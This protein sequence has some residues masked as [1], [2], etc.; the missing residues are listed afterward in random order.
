MAIKFLLLDKE[1]KFYSVFGD[2]LDITGHKL[3]VAFDEAKAVELLNVLSPDF[4]ILNFKDI[5]FFWDITKK[6]KFLLPIFLVEDYEQVEAIKQLG[7]S[8]FNI[9]MLPFNPLEFLNKTAKFLRLSKSIKDT[10]PTN[11]GITNIILSL[12]SKQAY[13]SLLL[14]KENRVCEVFLKDGFVKGLSCT[15]A[16]FMEIIKMEDVSVSLFPYGSEANLNTYFKSNEEFFS[17]FTLPS[18]EEVQEVAQEVRLKIEGPGIFSISDGLFLLSFI[19]KN[20]L[21]QKNVYLRIYERDGLRIPMLFNL[22]PSQQ[23]LT[24]KERVES[25]LGGLEHLRGLILMDLL[26]EDVQSIINLLSANPKLYIITSLPIA[27]SLISLG[28]PEKRMKLIESLVDDT[29]N[30]GTGDTLRF[31][32]VPFLPDKGSFVVFEENTKILFSSKLFSSYCLPEEYS[33][34]STA[35][36]KMI[37]LYHSVNFPTLEN[38]VSL[39]RVRLFNPTAIRPAFGNPILENVDELIDKIS[40]HR[41]FFNQANLEDE[42]LILGL[43]NSILFEVKEEFSKEKYESLLDILSEYAEVEN[44]V[45]SKI[46]VDVRRFPELFFYI[47]LSAKP[48]PKLLLSALYKFV[49]ADIPL[50]TI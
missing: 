17:M 42:P 14:Q 18:L 35:K 33:P 15:P 47:L 19:D 4:L 34:N 12:L 5:N 43:V 21:L 30:L 10:V 9:L 32:K 39:A 24:L 37:M 3:M 6:G 28:V 40:K 16:E 45:V 13:V 11:F 38:S 2:V 29:L 46:F 27:L 8:D 25:F 41:V 7:F 26:P 48:T 22:V 50:F 31:V 20:G 49:K 36:E 44:G 23:F 1:R